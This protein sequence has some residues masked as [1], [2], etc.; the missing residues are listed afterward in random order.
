MFISIDVPDGRSG[1]WEVSTFAIDDEAARF[2]NRINPRCPV[3]AGF[4]KQLIQGGHQWMTTLP[5]EIE[6]Q[7]EF[8][9][10]AHGSVL[11]TGLGLGA[12]LQLVLE[13][14]EVTD[15]TVLEQSVDVINLVASTYQNDARLEIVCA[16]AFN[17]VP[18]HRYDVVWH[19]IWPTVA[20]SNVPEID[21]LKKRYAPYA[22]WQGAW[23]EQEAR[24]LLR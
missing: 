8:I 20:A 14:P 15:V 2:R 24:E 21:A 10:R 16:D 7:R 9:E 23:C 3:H 19:D 12:V 6:Q 1:E 18:V 5:E 11:I 4:Y 17:W 13:K 22:D